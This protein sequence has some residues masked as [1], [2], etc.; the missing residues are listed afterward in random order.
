MTQEQIVNLLIHSTT[1]LGKH[2]KTHNPPVRK[3]KAIISLTLW[4][5]KKSTIPIYVSKKKSLT[6]RLLYLFLLL[7]WRRSIYFP[8]SLLKHESREKN[9]SKSGLCA[10]DEVLHILVSSTSQ[11]HFPQEEIVDLLET[12]K[13]IPV[14]KMQKAELL[15][16]LTTEVKGK[17]LSEKWFMCLR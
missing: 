10:L 15:C 6:L 11:K 4:D 5:I 12:T 17:E 1:P 14:S 2:V 16:Q 13:P 8:N 3:M 9:Y 7:R